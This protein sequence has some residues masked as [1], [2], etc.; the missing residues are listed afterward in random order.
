MESRVLAME[1][2]QNS[3]LSRRISVERN[4]SQGTCMQQQQLLHVAPQMPPLPPPHLS[5][6]Y[7]SAWQAT[8][9]RPSMVTHQTMQ[10]QDSTFSGT[11]TF[12]TNEP[13][14]D[15]LPSSNPNPKPK[16]ILTLNNLLPSSA[17]NKEKL[18]SC[19]AILSKYPKLRGESKAPTLA[20]KLAHECFFGDKVLVQ[21]TPGG[22]RNLPAL[23]ISELNQLKEVIFTQ[24]SN[25]WYNQLEFESKVWTP[26]FNA[27][28][29]ACKRLRNPR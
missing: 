28:G 5:W 12:P 8:M 17:I 3:I 23:P 24:F 22:G 21:C 1:D 9:Q 19:T 27:I 11:Y 13:T 6:D 18:K 20:V 14:G 2:S 29:Q 26:C 7:Q 15:S 10:A 16:P 4:V 25:L